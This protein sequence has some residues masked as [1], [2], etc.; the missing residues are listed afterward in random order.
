M[1]RGYTQPTENPNIFARPNSRP[2]SC[3]TLRSAHAHSGG[4]TVG[5][6]A[7][8]LDAHG[9]HVIVAGRVRHDLGQGREAL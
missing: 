9:A 3:G 5:A 8:A 6:L 4:Y 1:R 2:G 7:Y